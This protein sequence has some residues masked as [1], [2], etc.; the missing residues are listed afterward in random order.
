MRCRSRGIWSWWL[1]MILFSASGLAAQNSVPPRPTAV[2]VLVDG[3][4]SF[5]G[6]RN[7]A[8]KDLCELL[9][10]RAGWAI[11]SPYGSSA[12]GGYPGGGISPSDFKSELSYHWR[13]FGADVPKQEAVSV[14]RDWCTGNLEESNFYR[15]NEWLRELARESPGRDIIFI[16]TDFKHVAPGLRQDLFASFLAGETPASVSSPAKDSED[17]IVTIRP[18][19]DLDAGKASLQQ[20]VLFAVTRG[21]RTWVDS[22]LPS[23]SNRAHFQLA[24]NS[25]KSVFHC[26]NLKGKPELEAPWP[27]A[28]ALPWVNDVTLSK[29]TSVG[30]EHRFEFSLK[31]KASEK[32][33]IVSSC[34]G[35][36]E[37]HCVLKADESLKVSWLFHLVDSALI[38]G[39]L[40]YSSPAFNSSPNATPKPPDVKE[41]Q[42]VLFSRGISEPVGIPQKL[43][44][45]EELSSNRGF[46]IAATVPYELR[47][48]VSQADHIRVLVDGTPVHRVLMGDQDPCLVPVDS[49]P[50]L[51]ARQIVYFV[52]LPSALLALLISLKY[53]RLPKLDRQSLVDQASFVPT[54]L[55]VLVPLL[56]GLLPQN[57]AVNQGEVPATLRWVSVAVGAFATFAGLRIIHLLLEILPRL[58][59]LL[60]KSGRRLAGRGWWVVL[61]AILPVL[62]FILLGGLLSHTFLQNVLREVKPQDREIAEL[63]GPPSPVVDSGTCPGSD[64]PLYTAGLLPPEVTSRAPTELIFHELISEILEQVGAGGS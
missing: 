4:K 25:V 19:Y 42:L 33:E 49:L 9:G 50:H 56:L 62:V 48:Q 64:G 7:D 30:D 14:D 11:C 44:F 36:A 15:V 1:M 24:L 22:E 47:R 52:L 63:S 54:L 45:S 23:A 2:H 12:A 6:H 37:A 21:Y 27:P 39:H 31:S 29:I 60:L 26:T 58:K 17:W 3:S 34:N 10:N 41:I 35:A 43:A 28:G 16:L 40:M 18:G 53:A 57:V 13:C 55:A 32:F 51:I 59:S 38:V 20:E 5:A 46:R 8:I 61:R